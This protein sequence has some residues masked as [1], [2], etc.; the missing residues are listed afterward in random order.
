MFTR[1]YTA[2]VSLARSEALPAPRAPGALRE[3]AQNGAQLALRRELPAMKLSERLADPAGYRRLQ[4][5][6]R[7][8]LEALLLVEPDG[9]VVR[10]ATD[11]ICMIAEESAWSANPGGV[12][13][14]DEHHPEIDFQAAETAMLFAW[15]ARGLG[16]A[17]DP[18]VSAKLLY[19]V[20]R[21]LFSP[22]LAHGDYPFMRGRGP[23]PLCALSDIL[24]CLILME[25]DSAR[26]NAVLKPLLRQLDQAVNAL[27][28]RTM[29]LADRLAETG[30]VTDLCLL[31]RK[32]TRGELDLTEIYPTPDWLDAL[33]YPWLEGEY[34]L[35]PATRNMRPALSGQEVFRIGLAANDEALT[36]L[37]ARLDR[38]SKLPSATLTGRLMDMGCAGMLSAEA[39]K[40][41]RIKRAATP[42]N[43]MM[44]SRFGSLTFAMHTGGGQGNAGNV[45][46][47][48]GKEPLLVEV[49]EE[50]NLPVI[51]RYRQ[52]DNPGLLGSGA[53]FDADPCPADFQLQADQEMMSIDLTRAWPMEAGM[54]S[55]QRTAIILRREGV[56]RLLDAIEL[57][58]T[59]EV[60]FRFVTPQTPTRLMCGLRLGP[61][62]LT[63]EG[64]LK[65]D[66]AP[67]GRSFPANDATGDPL[68]RIELKAVANAGRSFFNFSFSPDQG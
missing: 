12:P 26:R 9:E 57:E 46:L 66:I 43:R 47:F 63:W 33:L 32:A 5:A 7:Q 65:A 60:S 8:A 67:L 53:S 11:L 35:D 45:V 29:P 24:L 17:L 20:R 16:E 64:E 40:P 62:D 23:R 2:L 68:Y 41:P 42:F 22:Y 25:T 55:C 58:T 30:A 1:G 6:R 14:E 19:E 39:G 31:L 44:I 49:P 15:T 4:R 50:A 34:F 36:A 13:F 59:S 10:R 37:G 56:V 28:G 3:W 52:A 18:R 61:V 21:R 38:A 48:F 51:S 27:T 54:R